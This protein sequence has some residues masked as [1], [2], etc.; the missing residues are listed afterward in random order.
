VADAG[1]RFTLKRFLSFS[2][3]AS[4]RGLA[5]TQPALATG[6]MSEDVLA[7]RRGR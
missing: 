1:S 7:A 2:R 3:S 6:V 5:P 4:P